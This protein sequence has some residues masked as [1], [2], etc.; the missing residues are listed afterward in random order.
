MMGRL[1]GKLTDQRRETEMD[2]KRE[3]KMQCALK[4]PGNTETGRAED[5]GSGGR[6]EPGG[7]ELEKA[8]K[9]EM[10]GG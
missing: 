2:D 4:P 3:E 9:T 8:G 1:Q 10:V 5:K 7:C 6:S